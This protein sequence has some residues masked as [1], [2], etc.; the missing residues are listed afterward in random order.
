MFSYSTFKALHFAFGFVSFETQFGIQSQCILSSIYYTYRIFFHCND[1]DKERE[2][3]TT[4]FRIGWQSNHVTKT[5]NNKKTR[6]EFE[7]YDFIANEWRRLAHFML[8][9]P[10][11]TK[12]FSWTYVYT[13]V[14]CVCLWLCFYFSSVFLFHVPFFLIFFL[15]FCHFNLK[16]MVKMTKLKIYISRASWDAVYYVIDGFINFSLVLAS[17]SNFFLLNLGGT[18]SIDCRRC[19]INGCATNYNTLETIETTAHGTY[20]ID[21]FGSVHFCDRYIA[22]ATAYCRFNGW[23]FMWN[24]FNYNNGSIPEH[25]NKIWT[26]SKGKPIKMSHIKWCWL[27]QFPIENSVIVSYY[28]NLTQD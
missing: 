1:N 8:S 11:F 15:L 22:M 12:K 6:K 21:L 17:H 18:V 13:V 14:L 5:K 3:E 7:F 4:I 26:Q 23:H 25:Y 19:I 27:W 16:F 24:C 9:R 20:E 28:F 2:R 10:N